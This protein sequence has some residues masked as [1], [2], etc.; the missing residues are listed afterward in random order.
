MSKN[1]G[2]VAGYFVMSKDGH[3]DIFVCKTCVDQHALSVSNP[4]SIEDYTF[5]PMRCGI[6]LLHGR[7]E[8]YG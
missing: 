3:S 7:P 2:G 8:D 4:L 1:E 6:H 5:L